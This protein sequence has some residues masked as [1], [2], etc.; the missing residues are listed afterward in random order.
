M[1]A[2]ARDAQREATRRRK[3]MHQAIGRR[4][5]QALR[6]ALGRLYDP[7]ET[8]LGQLGEVARVETFAPVVEGLVAAHIFARETS[9]CHEMALNLEHTHAAFGLPE[10]DVEAI[11]RQLRSLD[12]GADARAIDW[13][14]GTCLHGR[15]RPFRHE[16]CYE[17]P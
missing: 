12:D 7:E 15:V 13:C 10:A 16:A 8:P 14:A 11:R 4:D 1:G 17:P 9:L 3:Q 6:E 5:L 2:E